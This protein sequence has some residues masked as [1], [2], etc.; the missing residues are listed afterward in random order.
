MLGA[1]LAGL[2]IW[3]VAPASRWL[4]RAQLALGAS[5]CEQAATSQELPAGGTP[6]G[7]PPG[8]RRYQTCYTF[9][10][11]P[12]RVRSCAVSF[13]L[14]LLSSLSHS[15]FRP[16][17]TSLYL[18]RHDEAQ[19][20]GR[21]VGFARRQ[22]G[23][24]QRGRCQS[25]GQHEDAAHLDRAHGWR[26][27]AGDHCR[28]G[29]RPSALGAGWEA[30][31]V[32]LDETS[33]VRR[34][35]SRDFDE[36]HGTVT[37]SWIADLDCHRGRRRTLVARWQEHPLHF[38]CLSRVR[39]SACRSGA[40]ATQKK[41]DDAEQSKVKGANFHSSALSPLECIQGRQAQPHFRDCGSS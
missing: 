1:A 19:A 2:P 36:R 6:A 8:R 7:Q 16:G 14:R 31:C 32:Y 33:A 3:T 34:S 22:V 15:R 20:R 41:L 18:R 38:R 5:I 24:L 10:R 40:L 21:A 35:G 12:R 28:S 29:C 37:G 11:L 4:S 25:R 23:D 30:V 9:L 17:Q 39:R 27:G 26:S 13:S